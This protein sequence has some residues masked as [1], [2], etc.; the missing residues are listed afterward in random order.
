MIALARD[1]AHDHE[2]LNQDADLAHINDVQNFAAALNDIAFALAHR[3]N[4]TRYIANR[5]R[6]QGSRRS[7]Y[8]HHGGRYDS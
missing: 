5:L 4:R 2:I 7:D 8:H 6:R 3:I 1:L